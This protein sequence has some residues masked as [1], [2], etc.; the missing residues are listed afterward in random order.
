MPPN[1]SPKGWLI[2]QWLLSVTATLCVLGGLVV[3]SMCE[4]IGCWRKLGGQDQSFTGSGSSTLS[5]L[6]C[7]N[8]LFQCCG[9]I[10]FMDFVP[11]KIIGDG[12][13]I[14]LNNTLK[15][16]LI[17]LYGCALIN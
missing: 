2:L 15:T 9:A 4:R 12:V 7:N 13:V 3:Y 10:Y 5:Q 14:L 11:I 17:K 6:G 8:S 16:I 1:L